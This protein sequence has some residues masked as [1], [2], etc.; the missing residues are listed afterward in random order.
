MD[1]EDPVQK[2]QD[3]VQTV[4]V[5]HRPENTGMSS[6]LCHDLSLDFPQHRKIP[7]VRWAPFATLAGC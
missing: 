3:P 1:L 4:E 6:K 2:R 5:I 7:E